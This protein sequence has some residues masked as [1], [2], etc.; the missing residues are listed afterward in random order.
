MHFTMQVNNHILT[1]DLQEN[2]IGL[3][4]PKQALVF[5]CL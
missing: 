2:P 5:I 1:K 4:F 3:T